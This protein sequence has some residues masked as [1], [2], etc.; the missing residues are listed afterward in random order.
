MYEE[1][2]AW[3]RWGE[4]RSRI[5]SVV[6]GTRQGSVLSPAL[7]SVYM[8][9]LIARLRKSGVGCHIGGVFCGVVG[10]ADDL[11]LMAPSRSAMETMLGLCEEYAAENNLEFST[12]PNP[13]KSKSKCIFMSGHLRRPEPANLKLYGVDLPWVKKATHLGHEIS[14]DCMMI[15]DMKCKRGSFISRSTEIRETFKFAQPNQILQAVQ[16]YCLDMYGA[17]AWPLYSEKARQVFNSWSTCVKLA[18]GVPRATRTYLVDNLLSAG[19][20]SVRACVLAR[21]CKF[22]FSLRSSPSMEVRVVANL[23][24]AD[25]RSITGSNVHNIE[26]EAG[27]K[28]NED[29]LGKLRQT[30]LNTKTEVPS[31]DTWRIACLRKFLSERYEMKSKCQD[32]EP[33]QILIDSLCTS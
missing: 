12:D 20:P 17:M 8:D 33:V 28:L 32:T 9:D 21:Y 30:L 29:N 13:V 5:F 1:Q 7:F 23:A 19:I 16:T 27:Q 15:E 22:L 26:M 10:Y 25:I 18:W 11:L 24:G 31:K 6:N 14:S 4:S 3:V 2:Q